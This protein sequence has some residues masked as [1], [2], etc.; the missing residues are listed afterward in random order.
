MTISLKRSLIAAALGL[1][2]AASGASAAAAQDKSYSIVT[3][4]KLS[5]IAW[6]NRME[7]GVKQFAKD[8]GNN[9]TQVGAATADSALQIQLIEDLVA[10]GVDAIT[11]VPNSPQ[12]L[13]PVLKRALDNNIVVIGHEGADLKNITYDVE[14]FDNKAYGEHLMKRLAEDM[15]EEGEYAVFVG[16]LTSNTHNQWVDAAIAYQKAHYPKMTLVVDKLESQEQQ[17]VAYQKTRELLRTHPNLKGVQGSAG[18][19]V[20]GAALA[21]EEAGLSGKV[22]IVGTSLPSIAGPYLGTE[23]DMISFWDPAKAGYAQDVLAVKALKKEPVKAGDDLG[24]EGYNDVKVDGKVVYGQ[25]WVDVT[26]ENA[27]KYDF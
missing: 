20:V 25:A 17:Q 21:V 27:D 19:D 18:T 5:G 23:I 11:V 8:T 22:K 3:V 15:G 9:A 12:A 24:V 13:E 7:E 26:E 2:I 10:R 6:F 4:V 16:Y 1:G 14:A